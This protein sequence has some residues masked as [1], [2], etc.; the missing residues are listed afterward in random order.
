MGDG[1]MGS[2]KSILILGGG[3]GGIS[4]AKRL[5]QLLGPHRIT[6]VERSREHVFAPSLLWLMT[7]Q[8]R[9]TDIT[10]PLKRLLDPGAELIEAE[11]EAILPDRNTVRTNMGELQYDYLVV[12]LGAELAP[13]ALP[14]FAEAAHSFFTLEGARALWSDIQAFGGGRVAVLVSSMPYK[15]PAAPYEAALLLDDALRRRGIR[16]QSRIDVF[17]PEPLPMPVAGTA[18]GQAV[19][20]ML[21]AKGIGFHP[22][23]TVTSIDPASHEMEFKDSPRVGFD[24]LA[25]V[26]P[27]RPPLVVRESPLAAESGWISVDKHT[28]QTRYP[29]IYAIGDVTA[30]KLPNGKMLPKAGVFAHG[31]GLVVAERIHDAIA[32]RALKATFGGLGYCWIEAGGGSAGFAS[33]NFYAEPDPDV[34]L[35]R[36]GRA[37]HWGKVLFE[38][39]WLGQGVGRSVAGMGLKLG[40]R[41]AGVPAEL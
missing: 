28:M 1:D 16:D 3:V 38:R 21:A 6:V 33:G 7:G 20:G 15:C 30:I 5:C 13:E 36:S 41:V 32:G 24:I 10:R 39:Y 23:L 2:S 17:T 22:S 18:M 29:D 11:V 4:T 8:R 25:G 35:P 27:H 12:A 40:G 14:G 34:G 9:S 31:E 26:A 37:W 19:V